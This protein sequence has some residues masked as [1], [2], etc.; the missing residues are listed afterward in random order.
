MKK[1]S[2]IGLMMFAMNI[3]SIT[4]AA[5][6][7]IINNTNY[8]STSILNNGAC[9]DILGASGI[10]RAHS[11]NIVPEATLNKGCIFNKVNC[12][13]EVHMTNNCSGPAIATVIFDIKN[14]IKNVVPSNTPAGYSVTGSGFIAS[15]DG[16]PAMKNW[17]QKIFGL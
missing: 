3:P 2:L 6:L 16:G 5:S 11:T 8:D 7:T 10:S 12:K 9:S 13:A 4:L 14:G 15:I 1:K 17:F